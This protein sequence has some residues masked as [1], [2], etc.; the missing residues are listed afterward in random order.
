M[1]ELE[2]DAQA[3]CAVNG[4]VPGIET[5]EV[6]IFLKTESN[7]VEFTLCEHRDVSRG[8]VPEADESIE[9][10]FCARLGAFTLGN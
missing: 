6:R 4:R 7:V 1:R 2:M 9:T 3:E 10:E 5:K 8:I